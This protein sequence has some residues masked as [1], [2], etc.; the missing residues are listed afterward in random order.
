MEHIANFRSQVVKL[1]ELANPE[2]EEFSFA[3]CESQLEQVQ[4]AY[5]NTK[6]VLLKAGAE[7]RAPIPGVIDTLEQNSRIR[8]M[9]RQ[10]F[11][12]IHYLSEIYVDAEV[13]VPE[14]KEPVVLE[15]KPESEKHT[16]T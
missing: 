16:L 1:M 14:K 2:L 12:A 7:L 10:M 13:Q 4:T 8:R 6:M 5:D 9:A 11:K 3:N 15:V